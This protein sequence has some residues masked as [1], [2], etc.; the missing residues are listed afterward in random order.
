MNNKQKIATVGL[1]VATVVVIIGAFLLFSNE[2]NTSSYITDRDTGETYNANV[3]NQQTG[4]SGNTADQSSAVLFGI[5]K[6]TKAAQSNGYEKIDFTTDVRDAISTYSLKNLQDNYDSI[7]L[8]PQNMSLNEGNITAQLRLGQGD[9]IIPIDITVVGD[10]QASLVSID[11]G[12]FIYIGG[13]NTLDRTLFTIS[14]SDYKGPN[15]TIDSFTYREAALTE[16]EDLGYN[17]SDLNIKFTN[18][19]NPFK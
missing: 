15:I 3:N 10:G 14:Q 4:G 16:I 9:K 8:R 1:L 18:Y 7:T 17:I 11:N 13:L 12:K 2:P 19:E 6:F 5:Q